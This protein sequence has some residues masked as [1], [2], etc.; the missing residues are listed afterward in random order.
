MR[1]VCLNLNHR[2]IGRDVP[3]SLVSE[4]GALEAD[5][6][7][8][9]EYVSGSRNRDLEQFLT[10]IGLSHISTSKQVV[11]SPGRFHNQ[12]LIASNK[13]FEQ[14]IHYQDSP[15]S[16]ANSNILTFLVNGLSLT[17]IRAP[18]YKTMSEWRKY[19]SWLGSA[20]L[21]DVL[22]GDLNVDPQ[23][24]N[25]RDRVYLDLVHSEGW[26]LTSVVGDWSFR[27]VKGNTAKL[28]HVL[29]RNGVTAVA[30]WYAQDS[31]V[32]A[33]TDHAALVV[34]LDR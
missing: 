17:G 3:R 21:G 34:D 20:A 25:S 7:V 30:A 12:I 19:W 26:T 11:Y 1:V 8:F 23:R 18:A 15:D 28:D 31:F 24:A 13:R 4:I 9:N 2:T 32:P 27:G 22:I 33:Y 16:G 10:E 6:L 14:V 29:V 5:V